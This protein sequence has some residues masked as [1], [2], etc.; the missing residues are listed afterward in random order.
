MRCAARRGSSLAA[1][2]A[3]AAHAAM[4]RA[5]AREPDLKDNPCWTLLRREAFSRFDRAF[6]DTNS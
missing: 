6:G 5:E 3:F 2:Q 4:V 1:E